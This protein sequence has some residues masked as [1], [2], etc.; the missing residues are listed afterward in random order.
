MVCLTCGNEWET[1][2]TG[3]R[4]RKCPVCG[5]YR[6]KF[7]KDLSKED[8]ENLTKSIQSLK[9]PEI[10]EIQNTEID[11]I[12]ENKAEKK[13]IS[14]KKEE[15]VRE[16]TPKKEKKL[17]N[18]IISLILEEEGEAGELSPD[19][20]SPKGGS[21]LFYALLIMAAAGIGYFLY[22][23]IGHRRDKSRAAKKMEIPERPEFRRA[24]PY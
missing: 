4:K 18:D 1:K 20:A 14:P 6:V 21:L 9:E 11:K 24:S 13:E 17:D 22:H 5:K 2:L 7:K 10:K 8:L 19:A 16:K 3:K 23:A 15:K 12:P